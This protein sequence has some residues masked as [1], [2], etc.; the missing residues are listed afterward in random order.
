[1]W[2]GKILLLVSLHE[3]GS[4]KKLNKSFNKTHPIQSCGDQSG[5]VSAWIVRPTGELNTA[6]L[7]Q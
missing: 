4:S 2:A 3:Q 7:T 6:G 1:M 5:E